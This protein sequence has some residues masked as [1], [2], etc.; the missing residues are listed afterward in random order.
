MQH[1]NPPLGDGRITMDRE[2]V[3]RRL[4]RLRITLDGSVVLMCENIQLAQLISSF[5]STMKESAVS[6]ENDADDSAWI[7][8]T[9]ST[10]G[11]F[12]E[13][14]ILGF[15]ISLSPKKGDSK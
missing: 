11:L 13:H 3:S 7:G 6:C 5:Q 8:F 14:D 15:S 10:G 12:E 4:H 1:K 9:A 2:M